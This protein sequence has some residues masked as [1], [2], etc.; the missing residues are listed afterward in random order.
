MRNKVLNRSITFGIT[1]LNHI[2][3]V[4]EGS[5]INGKQKFLIMRFKIDSDFQ[6]ADN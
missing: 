5:I 3:T 4:C 1:L 2:Y 6:L